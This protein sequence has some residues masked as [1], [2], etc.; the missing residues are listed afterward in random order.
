[1]PDHPPLSAKRPSWVVATLSGILFCSGV[2]TLIYQSVWLREFR[3]IFGQAAL[4]TSVEVA[5]FMAGLGVGGWWFGKRMEGVA[6]PFRSYAKLQIAVAVLAMI[7]PALLSVVRSLYLTS[8]GT[9]ALG[10]TGAVLVQLILTMLV[11]GPASFLMGGSLPAAMKFAQRDYDPGR[12]T[13]AFVYAIAFAGAATGAGV[14]TFWMLGTVGNHGT[15]HLASFLNA[16]IAALAW[17]AAQIAERKIIPVAVTFPEIPDLEG[18]SS[19][20]RKAPGA[21]ILAAGFVSGFTFLVINLVW[22]RLAAPLLGVSVYSAGVLLCIVL[23]GVALGSLLYSMML[24]HREPRIDDFVLVSTLQ[25]VAVMAP[26]VLGDDFA[27]ISLA[28]NYITNGFGFTSLVMGWIVVAMALSFVPSLMAG[29]QFPLLVSL[30]GRGNADVGKHF[31]RISLVTTAGAIVGGM[32]GGF[33]LIP[34]LG[35]R[36]C[37]YGMAGVIGLMPVAALLILT[38]K[39]QIASCVARSK[40]LRA[41][42][43]TLVAGLAGAIVFP[44][45]SSV[46]F[47]SPIGYGQIA[48]LPNSREKLEEWKRTIRR[49]HVES[50]DGREASVAVMDNDQYVLMTSGREESS[51]IDDAPTQ[52]ML[53]LTVAALHPSPQKAC[54]IGLGTGVTAGWL[55]DAQGINQVDCTEIEPRMQDLA[56]QFS[57]VNRHAMVHPKVN[58]IVADAREYFATAG[59]MYDLIVS[60]DADPTLDS[61]SSHFTTEYYQ[62]LHSHLNEGGILCQWVAAQAVTSETID[63][64]IA[65]L[66]HEFP[67]VEIWNSAGNDLLLIASAANRPWD[68]N[69]LRKRLEQEPFATATRRFWH[70]DNVEGF[71]SHCI[72]GEAFTKGIAK[73]ATAFNTDDINTVQFSFSQTVGKNKSHNTLDYRRRAHG[74]DMMLPKFTGAPFDDELLGR[75]L[76][77]CLWH[78]SRSAEHF[79]IHPGAPASPTI[80]QVA[81]AFE[82]YEKHNSADFEKAFDDT[83]PRTLEEKWLLTVDRSL[84]ADPRAPDALRVM[85]PVFPEDV[86]A[87]RTLFAYAK[88]DFSGARR[89]V[90]NV[91]D[92]LRK[93]PWTSIALL[94]SAMALGESLG[95]AQTRATPGDAKALYTALREPFAAGLGDDMRL[96]SMTWVS[97]HLNDALRLDMIEAWGPHFPWRGLPLAIRAGTHM[98]LHDPR[99]ESSMADI[100]AFLDGGGEIPNQKPKN[101][102][103]PTTAEVRRATPTGPE[104]VH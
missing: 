36:S 73:S 69:Q 100:Q 31:G 32:L 80:E 71:V 53:G 21:F 96:T 64:I 97:G 88:R 40:T 12:S 50:H 30:L 51:A 49:A 41:A 13:T 79:Q 27:F 35:L 10:I 90:I 3:L 95:N 65:T 58:H 89:G 33:V 45:P 68:A 83:K 93:S 57:A 43:A 54:V 4:A 81:G 98:S 28:V 75:E 59:S 9:Q 82:A 70:T 48:T 60:R 61:T 1:M 24:R 56:R 66:C 84:H 63:A 102:P 67:K 62:S 46:W 22:Q 86:A 23:G 101:S 14:S 42:C 18:D 76:I 34:L 11:V 2:C 15:L 85:E 94:K 99:L 5:V 78:S 103:A 38:H 74:H 104:A 37:W 72:A 87:L 91:C 19:V 6:S 77:G 55:A 39:K 47:H 29:M 16:V 7:S 44:G 17:G 92:T 25:A 20:H 26:A 8:G 52:V